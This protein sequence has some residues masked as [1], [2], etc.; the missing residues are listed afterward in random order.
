MHI[1]ILTASLFLSGATLWC[2]PQV[3]VTGL[4]GPNKILVTSGGNLLVTETS[5]VANAGRVSFVTRSGVRTSLI[6]GLPSGAEVTGGGSGPTAMAL[7]NRTLYLALGAGDTERSVAGSVTARMFNPAGYGSPLFGTIL[8]II[9]SRDVDSLGGTFRITPQIQQTLN[10]GAEVE[11]TNEGGATARIS[12][13]ARFPVAEPAPAPF[14]Y[15]FS[16]LWGLALS[17]NGR[18]LFVGDASSDSLSRVDTATGRW[19]RIARFPVIRNISPVGPPV[20]DPVPTSVRIYGDQVLVS[21]LTGFPFASGTARVLA[22]NADGS[23]EPFIFG[24]TSA[25]DVLRITRPDGQGQFFVIEFSANQSATAPPPGRLLK[26]DG[27][28]PQVAAT[29]LIT[30]VSLAYD[31]STQDLFILELRGQILRLIWN[32]SS[33]LIAAGLRVGLASCA[34]G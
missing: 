28:Q 32:S 34:C 2:Q 8:E 15:K 9:F 23:T 20:V 21:F 6:E 13:L 5:T 3:V 22:V 4:Q 14:F 25:T 26:F 7:R 19:R 30:P 11:V 16:N 10:D 18:D 27:P 24:L 1:K 17:A 12:V 33:L 31:P 29:G